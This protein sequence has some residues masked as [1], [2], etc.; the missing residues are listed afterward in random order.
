MQELL[1][2][3][4]IA[5]M[6]V[7]FYL[8]VLRPAKKRQADALATVNSVKAGDHVMTT[9]GIYG[10]VVSVEGDTLSLEVSPGVRLKYAKAAVARIIVDEPATDAP[11]L[12]AAGATAAAAAAPD[13]AAETPTTVDPGATAATTVTAVGPAAVDLD[14]PYQRGQS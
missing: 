4:F 13:A 8:L 1:P 6:F 7:G 12:P 11:A 5:V 2:L 14:N 10:E 9:A 3:A